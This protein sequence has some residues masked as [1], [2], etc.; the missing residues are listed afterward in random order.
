MRKEVVIV[1]AGGHAKVVADIIEKSGDIC[2]GFLDDGK[3]AGEKVLDKC[4]LGKVC[5]AHKFKDKLFFIAIGN[6]AIREDISKKLSDY[7]FYTAIHPTAVIGS[8]AAIGEGTCVMPYAVINSSA[9]IGRHCIINTSSI[10]EH[11]CVLDDFVHISPNATLCGNVNVGKLTHI[12]A[13]AV[14]INNISITQ[15]CIVGAGGVVVKNIN[16][17]GVYMG[18]PARIKNQG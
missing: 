4:V 14:V 5:D 1:G 10:V 2:I 6:N 15:S 17:S 7:N 8:Y 9:S 18:V 12:G 16:D 3:A 11:D 13:C